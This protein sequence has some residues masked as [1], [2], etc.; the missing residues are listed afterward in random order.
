MANY[1]YS[2]DLPMPSPDLSADEVIQLVI[3]SLQQNDAA[4]IGIEVAFNFA[5]P[6]NKLAT[7]PLNNFKQLVREP[8]FQPMLNF[9]TYKCSELITDGERAQQ[10]IVV[11]EEDGTDA[12]FLFS[13]SKQDDAPYRECWMTDSVTRVK[14]ELYG[15]EVK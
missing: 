15:V 13:L 3:E 5:S 14:P 7:G 2:I 9:C 10:I 1:Q 8:L 4:D 6:G 12:G 11:Q